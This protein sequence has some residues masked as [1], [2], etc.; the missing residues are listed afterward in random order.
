MAI[1]S[2]PIIFTFLYALA[3]SK[4][5]S[6][7]ETLS[8]GELLVLS[9]VLPGEV[10]QDIRTRGKRVAPNATEAPN[11]LVFYGPIVVL[12]GSCMMFAIVAIHDITEAELVNGVITASST[13]FTAA[14]TALKN[15]NGFNSIFVMVYSL[16]F[17][18]SL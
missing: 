1:G 13:N 10:Y 12:L 18:H 17:L 8:H 11:K 2:L 9:V 4:P 5:F 3:M 16:V 14:V 7:S 6:L 15:Q